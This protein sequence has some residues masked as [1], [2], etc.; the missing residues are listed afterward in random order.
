M[1]IVVFRPICDAE[2]TEKVWFLRNKV[3]IIKSRYGFEKKMGQKNGEIRFWK[4]GAHPT[5]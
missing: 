3:E 1:G 2:M 5:L 4:P